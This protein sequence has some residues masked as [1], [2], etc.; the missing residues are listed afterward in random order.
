MKVFVADAGTDRPE[1]SDVAAPWVAVGAAHDSTL[2][3]DTGV[4]RLQ[5]QDAER[6]TRDSASA[7][8]PDLG[9]Y[10]SDV[11][12]EINDTGVLSIIANHRA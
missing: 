6:L 11:A 2:P 7:Y 8:I 12:V 10:E 1:G 5:M 3:S 4:I 9:V